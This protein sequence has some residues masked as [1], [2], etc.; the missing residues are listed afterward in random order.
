MYKQFSIRAIER[1]DAEHMLHDLVGQAL[2]YGLKSPDMFFY[3]MGFGK[4]EIIESLNHRRQLLSTFAI[5]ASCYLKVIE[6]ECHKSILFSGN[7]NSE[8]FHEVIER[9]CGLT[10]KRIALSP[11]NDLWIDLGS[12]WLV[13]ITVESEEESWRFFS[14]T[15]DSCHLVAKASVIQ[16]HGDSFSAR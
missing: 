1:N 16:V 8:D 2:C 11:K 7:S 4:C 3:D 14:P 5:H 13:F 9:L 6:R 12:I 10:V 15:Q